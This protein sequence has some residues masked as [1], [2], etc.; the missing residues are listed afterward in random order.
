MGQ[1]RS[2]QPQKNKSHRSAAICATIGLAWIGLSGC[3][4][5]LTEIPLA[6]IAP[7]LFLIVAAPSPATTPRSE[8]S[9]MPTLPMQPTE[10]SAVP[11][12]PQ[13]AI[14]ADLDYAGHRLKAQEMIVYPNR[15]GETLTHISFDLLA[16]HRMGVFTL[17]GGTVQGDPAPVFSIDEAV[18]RVEFSKP[19]AADSTATIEITYTLDL[20]PILP[21]RDGMTGALGWSVHQINLGDWF[22]AVSA[23]RDG[24]F[25]ERNPPP[26]VGEATVPE[27]TDIFV[28]LGMTNAPEGLQI[29]ASAAAKTVDSRYQY[30]LPGARSFAMS[31]SAEWEISEITTSSGI[32]V[33]S[34]YGREHGEAG[35]AAMR[36]AADALEIFGEKF[37]PYR[38]R[39]LA[40][41]EAGFSDGMEYSGF[42]FLGRE[43]YPAYD[44]TPRNYLTAIAAH[45]TAHQWWYGDVGNDQA[46]EPWLDEAFCAYSELIYYQATRPD[47]ADWWWDYR[48][49]RFHPAGWVNASVYG[50]PEFRPYVNAVYLRGALFLRDLRAAMGDDA[51]FFF[52]SQYRAEESGRVASAKDFWSLLKIY[53][54]PGLDRIR[55][56][57]FKP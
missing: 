56:E 7:T 39:Q 44:G 14:R 24:W 42:F 12:L 10:I 30:A 33:R 50:L 41:V 38:Y 17:T 15:T 21:E 51:F 16:A 9:L 45:E 3:A 48:V 19:L 8:P 57:Y 20:P 18:L 53:D 55:A 4:G 34:A 32:L 43:F 27:A 2:I 13:V 25:S 49:A 46:R 28:D 40:L 1:T 26:A 29:M 22:A 37:G 11:V 47:L 52:I 6:T 35:L 36:A 54:V 23:Y 31:L 5:S